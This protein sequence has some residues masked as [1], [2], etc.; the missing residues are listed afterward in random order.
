MIDQDKAPVRYNRAANSVPANRG[1]ANQEVYAPNNVAQY[2]EPSRRQMGSMMKSFLLM[3]A[4]AAALAANQKLAPDAYKIS[5][6]LGEYEANIEEEVFA[7]TKDIETFYANQFEDYKGE[8]SKYV[9]ASNI[10]VRAHNDAVLQY[11]KA[12]YDRA[13]VLT[14]AV[15][16]L[17]A[18]VVQKFVNVAETLNSADLGISSGALAGGR[19]IGLFDP[20]LGEAFEQYGE[21]GGELA[22]AR[23]EDFFNRGM[24]IDI[25]KIDD[26]LPSPEDVTAE[27]D[28]IELPDAPT[29]PRI[30]VYG[31]RT[32]GGGE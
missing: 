31:E 16:N 3:G 32:I 9:E 25:P 22:A 11:Y 8:V 17:R 6:L 14:Q 10:A 21:T 23:L 30:R 29:P 13:Q 4:G 27:L 2:P 19:L 28:E 18:F 24:A 12:A 1:N 5:T 20:S 15:V 26:V 7:Q